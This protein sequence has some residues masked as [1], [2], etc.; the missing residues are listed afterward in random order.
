[1]LTELK[2]EAYEANLQLPRHGLIHLNFGNASAL[3]RGRGIF[4]IKPSGVDY[5][6]LRPADM[7][8]VDLEGKRVEGRLRPSSDTPTHAALY[9]GFAAVGGIVHTHSFYAT[10]FAQ[11]GRPIPVLGTTHSDFFCGAVPVTRAMT[12]REIAGDYEAA[13]GRV[14][15]KRFS[16]LDPGEIP[17]VLVLHHG[18]FAWGR[19][20][21]EA[22]EYAVAM[23]LCAKLAFH[24]LALGSVG[25]KIISELMNRHFR[26]KHGPQA[27]YGQK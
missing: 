19:D 14:I 9:A 10:A 4:A 22:V 21:A 3:D 15:L 6:A 23:E 16:K 25:T 17:G 7:V 24:T 12:K 27:Y 11:A 13:T 5:A 2:R 20:A 26:R 1:M 18:P 8:L